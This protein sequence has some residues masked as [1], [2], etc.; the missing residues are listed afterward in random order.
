MS[1]L[2]RNT[3]GILHDVQYSAHRT[4]DCLIVGLYESLVLTNRIQQHIYASF[5]NLVIRSALSCLLS[6]SYICGML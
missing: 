4:G 3:A 1:S 2:F 6:V 5:T